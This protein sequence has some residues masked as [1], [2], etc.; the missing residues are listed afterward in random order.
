[1]DP[2]R[3]ISVT[4]PSLR[5]SDEDYKTIAE[6]AIMLQSKRQ[7]AQDWA[8]IWIHKGL[9]KKDNLYQCEVSLRTQT[10]TLSEREFESEV[11]REKR[12]VEFCGRKAHEELDRAEKY[13]AEYKE[14]FEKYEDALKRYRGEQEKGKSAR[15]RCWTCTH[16]R[17]SSALFELQEKAVQW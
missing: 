10:P 11:M 9:E 2:E 14:N 16:L 8:N 3:P 15:L 6:K 13:D 17:A 12:I 1:M 5:N 7:S 4:A